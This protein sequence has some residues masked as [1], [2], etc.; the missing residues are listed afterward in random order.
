MENQSK[1]VVTSFLNAVQTGDNA[2]LAEL[3]SAEII[4]EQPGSNQV[5]GLKNSNAE[6]FQMVGKMFEISGNTLRLAEIKSV[7]ANNNEVAAL[8]RWEASKPSGETLAVDNIDVYRVENGQ[9]ISAKI[10]TSDI[11]AEDQFWA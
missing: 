10:F 5:S 3:L 4:W 1:Q 8:L 9:I 11:K 7:T 6:V 2:K